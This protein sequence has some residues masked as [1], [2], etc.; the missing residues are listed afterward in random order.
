VWVLAMERRVR[1]SNCMSQANN[2]GWVV[3][4]EEIRRRCAPQNDNGSEAGR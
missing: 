3:A 1:Q 4:A 2:C